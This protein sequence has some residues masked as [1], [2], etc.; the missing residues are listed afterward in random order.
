MNNQNIPSVEELRNRIQGTIVHSIP[1]EV[2]S[3]VLGDEEE[4]PS[5]V[6]F[7]NVDTTA[8]EVLV[9][10]EDE[11][12]AGGYFKNL[13]QVSVATLIAV[14]VHPRTPDSV[15]EALQDWADVAVDEW[16]QLALVSNPNAPAWYGGA[17]DF[18]SVVLAYVAN[19][20]VPLECVE[21]VL[22]DLENEKYSEWFYDEST[23]EV[24]DEIR[25]VALSRIAEA[26]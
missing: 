4:E 8:E 2:A 17:S 6:V 7:P 3:R 23:P 26:D 15:L 11:D 16:L 12:T 14:A 5:A 13:G 25:A 19:A 20:D 1:V 21:T 9:W 22:N 24:L 10:Y 18:P